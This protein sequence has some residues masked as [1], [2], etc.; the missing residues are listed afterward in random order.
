MLM[1]NSTF[2]WI[3]KQESKFLLIKVVV[4]LFHHDKNKQS[5]SCIVNLFLRFSLFLK[6]LE[7][8]VVQEENVILI[9]LCKVPS[10]WKW[11]EKKLKK[12]EVVILR[13][14]PW[15]PQ[16][17]L[18][19]SPALS[20]VFCQKV[21]GTVHITLLQCIHLSPPTQ[22][23]SPRATRTLFLLKLFPLASHN[24]HF[25]KRK[26]LWYITTNLLAWAN[27][28]KTRLDEINRKE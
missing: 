12:T 18:C 8:T 21:R 15:Q 10:C 5:W 20:L 19:H 26:T 7:D 25:I 4:P 11:R 9:W 14:F 3:A 13:V 27:Q 2:S 6:Y 1:T 17:P 23:L 22:V 24:I 28:S 16:E